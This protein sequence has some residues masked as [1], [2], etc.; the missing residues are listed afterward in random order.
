MRG[1]VHYYLSRLLNLTAATIVL[2]KRETNVEPI[3]I[4]S[5]PVAEQVLFQIIVLKPGAVYRSPIIYPMAV[6]NS[7]KTLARRPS[8]E[9]RSIVIV[10]GVHW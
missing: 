10:S 8:N 7:R 1:Y 4:H 9:D 5:A 2:V 3:G 6:E